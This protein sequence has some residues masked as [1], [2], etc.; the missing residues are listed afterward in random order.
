MTSLSL[1]TWMTARELLSLLL[2]FWKSILFSSF[3]QAW[4]LASLVQWI[5]CQ[6]LKDPKFNSGQGHITPTMLEAT[7]QC[8]FLTSMFCFVLFS[9][10][11]F[12]FLSMWKLKKKKKAE[13]EMISNV[14]KVIHLVLGDQNSGWFPSLQYTCHLFGLILRQAGKL[15]C[16][17]YFP[18]E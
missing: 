4:I 15:L 14:F 17:F 13:T 18:D 5:G 8:F 7:S 1:G 16:K 6:G 3:S 10:S 11:P 9:S 12:L 2:C